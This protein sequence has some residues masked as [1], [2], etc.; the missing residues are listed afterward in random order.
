MPNKPSKTDSRILQLEQVIKKLKFELIE[1]R[2]EVA[3]LKRNIG[4]IEGQP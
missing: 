3:V 4:K 1:S 2:K